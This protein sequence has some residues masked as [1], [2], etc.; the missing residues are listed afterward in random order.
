MRYFES[1][2]ERYISKIGP[3]S[4]EASS[5]MLTVEQD[6]KFIPAHKFSRDKIRAMKRAH[7]NGE[8]MTSIGKR[9]GISV[10]AM[11]RIL[12]KDQLK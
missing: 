8:T 10:A 11:R 12:K 9:Y 1:V 3:V 4:E 2:F 7:R 6:K 5:Q